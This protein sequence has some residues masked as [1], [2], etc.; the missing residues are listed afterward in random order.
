MRKLV[1]GRKLKLRQ[2]KLHLY[3]YDAV[4]SDI[5]EKLPSVGSPSQV[6]IVP[7]NPPASEREHTP[8][9]ETSTEL[10][11]LGEKINVGTN[12]LVNELIDVDMGDSE[13][14]YYMQKK[15]ASSAPQKSISTSKGPTRDNS[16]M[17]SSG[18][19]QSDS[20]P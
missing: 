7:V 5:P 11:E 2:C 12:P 19:S 3:L 20:T 1:T 6:S 16:E 18:H 14:G 10:N 9:R 4:F 15:R 8:P 17:E 13:S